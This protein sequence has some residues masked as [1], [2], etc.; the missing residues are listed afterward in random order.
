LA[1][2]GADFPDRG[3]REINVSVQTPAPIQLE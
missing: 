3:D 2:G 1:L